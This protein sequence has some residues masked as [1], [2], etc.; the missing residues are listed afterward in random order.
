MPQNSIETHTVTQVLYCLQILPHFASNSSAFFFECSARFSGVL[1]AAT[2]GS[3]Y[4]SNHELKQ[5]SY[6]FFRGVHSSDKLWDMDERLWM[7]YAQRK[8]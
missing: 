3:K 2:A 8:G 5:E 1:A 4:P 6:S 7:C